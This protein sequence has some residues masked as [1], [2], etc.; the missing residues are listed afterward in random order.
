MGGINLISLFDEIDKEA[1]KKATIEVLSQFRKLNMV[2]KREIQQKLTTSFDSQPKGTSQEPVIERKIITKLYAE[3][4][5]DRIKKAIDNI[6]NED[7]QK[8]L[9]ALF[10]DG[11]EKTDAQIINYYMW[12][13]STYYKYK[14]LALEQAA[15]ALGCEQYTKVVP[16]FPKHGE[17]ME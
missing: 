17:K 12:P 1:T 7:S 4:E 2:A 15:W 3:Q 10:I 13:S 6:P 9:N 16:Q 5:T 14:D 11:Y 8:I